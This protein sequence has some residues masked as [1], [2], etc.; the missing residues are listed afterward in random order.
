[1]EK[2]PL[3]EYE[4][5]TEAEEVDF[6]IAD[7]TVWAADFETTT[8]KNLEID[9]CVRVYLWSLVSADLTQEY[10]GFDIEDFITQLR[11]LQCDIVFFHNLAFDGSFILAHFEENGWRY[12]IDYTC[13]IDEMN[14][15]YQISIFNLGKE[16]KIWDSLK[17]FP[18]QSVKSLA[19]LY[20][21]P[22]K[23]APPFFDRYIPEDY[24]PPQDEIEYCVQDSRI[25][26]NAVSKE[27]ANGHKSLTLS[28][29]AFTDVKKSLGG[30]I[31]WR[32]FMPKL[33][34]RLDASLRD[35][36]KGGWTYLNPLYYNIDLPNVCVYDVNSL[37]PY[38]MKYCQ[39]PYGKPL[40]R[41]HKE[42]ELYIKRF[43]TC[44]RLKK[45]YLP[46]IQIK[47]NFRFNETEYLTDS[48]GEVELCLT[49]IDFDLFMEHYEVDYLRDEVEISFKS[50]VGMLGDYIDYHMDQKI[51]AQL[52]G[53]AALRYLSKRYLN[54]PYGK[55]GMRPNR[56]NKIPYLDDDGVVRFLEMETVSDPIYIPYATFV[57]AQARNI[58]IRAAQANYDKFIYADT[59][60]IH[61][62]GEDV[63]G[64]K[65]HDTELGAWK[66]E[67]KFELGKYLRSKTYIHGNKDR[68]IVEIK[69]AGMPIEVKE[70]VT[71][72]DFRL[73]MK[74][75]GKMMKKTVKGG[76]LL[77]P[78]TFELK[79]YNV[80]ELFG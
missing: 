23:K 6:N 13:V 74:F 25:V 67:G 35:S 76:C 54:S 48:K 68:E 71:W 27:W 62:L 51:K 47:N 73:G 21:Y 24:I 18:S 32:N 52:D 59:D 41:P 36:Y 3:Y 66:C 44:F 16:I 28:S 69:C 43:K 33:S 2:Y 11:V 78:T 19:K 5:T 38:V 30:F 20:G 22:D 77:V 26:A 64:I 17:K 65:I 37:Y 31:K 9:G 14:N 29:D 46:T 34:K 12:G 61:I 58:T 70:K 39:L 45:G 50:V 42:G 72:E 40:F 15:W 55:T 10:Y 49:S 53:N 8:Q 1:M 63:K 80:N 57:T 79:E 75:D 60:S 4:N 56:V 7:K